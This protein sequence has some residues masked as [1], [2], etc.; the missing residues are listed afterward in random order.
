M[1]AIFMYWVNASILARISQ[2]RALE[3]A[4]S[5]YIASLFNEPGLRWMLH[6]NTVHLREVQANNNQEVT[7]N[8][9][10][11]ETAENETFNCFN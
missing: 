9:E 6:D 4:C 3:E 10:Q 1:S 11:L 5:F 2:S 7:Y 8:K